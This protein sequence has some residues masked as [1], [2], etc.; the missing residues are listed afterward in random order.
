[1]SAVVSHTDAVYNHLVV[2][3][4]CTTVISVYGCIFFVYVCTEPGDGSTQPKRV[5]VIVEFNGQMLC[6]TVSLFVDKIYGILD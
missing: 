1:V 2:K 6:S 5:A 3:R 4:D